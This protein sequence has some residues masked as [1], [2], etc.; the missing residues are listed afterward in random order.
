MNQPPAPWRGSIDNFRKLFCIYF[1]Q[2]TTHTISNFY[3]A[4]SGRRVIY[5][6][7]YPRRCP[8]GTLP[9]GWFIPG[10][11]PKELQGNG[12]MELTYWHKPEPVCLNTLTYWHEPEVVCPN[13]LTYCHKLKP[14]CHNTLTYSHKPEP[15]CPNTLKYLPKRDLVCPNTL[16]FSDEWFCVFLMRSV[17]FL[18]GTEIQS[19]R[20]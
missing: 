10:F 6:L 17:F 13:T 14:V 8:F 1:N 19:K 12:G 2:V 16:M 4:L 11:Q 18:I 3:V 15:V 5:V 9:L 20:V 7:I